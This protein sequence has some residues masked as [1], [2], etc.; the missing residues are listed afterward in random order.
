MSQLNFDATQ[1]EPQSSFEPLPSGEYQVMIKESEMKPTRDGTGS[2]L[3]ITLEVIDGNH[4]GRLLWDR[5][6]LQNSNAVAV[7]IAQKQLSAIC[8]AVN[9]LNV[10]DSAQLHNIPMIAKVAYR[11]A[12]NGYDASNDVKAYKKIVNSAPSFNH[13]EPQKK[14]PAWN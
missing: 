7:E 8:H 6:N 4:K 2:Y 12:R 10:S 5:L 11:D 13:A 1:I 3:Q 9:V 14:Q